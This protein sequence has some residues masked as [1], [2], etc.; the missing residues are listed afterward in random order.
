MLFAERTNTIA[1][2]PDICLPFLKDKKIYIYHFNP[3]IKF[4]VSLIYRKNKLKVS[5]IQEFLEKFELY[6]NKKNF[7]TRLDEL[8]GRK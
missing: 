2:I 7:I 4:D 1:A 6:L 8:A 3:A 5:I